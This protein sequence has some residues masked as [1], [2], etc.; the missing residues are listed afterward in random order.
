MTRAR[1]LLWLFF[2]LGGLAIVTPAVTHA[3]EPGMEGE[4]GGSSGDPLYGYLGTVALAG[5]A[6]FILCKSARRN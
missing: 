6:V 3:Q 2:L 5:G 4:S 1:R